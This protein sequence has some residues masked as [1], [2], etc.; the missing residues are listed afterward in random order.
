MSSH[1]AVTWGERGSV[2]PPEGILTPD[3]IVPGMTFTS[4]VPGSNTDPILRG[5]FLAYPKWTGDELHAVD[6][7]ID[8][9]DGTSTIELCALGIGSNRE[10]EIASRVCIETTS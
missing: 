8:G 7:Q 5:K 3:D 2:A 4:Y 10:G 1:E 6:A 9:R